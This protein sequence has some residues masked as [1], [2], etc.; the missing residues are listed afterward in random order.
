[1]G[2]ISAVTIRNEYKNRFENILKDLL[3][4][5]NFRFM[6]TVYY[7]NLTKAVAKK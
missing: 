6:T 7:K 2:I 1:M 3:S 5:D 4:F